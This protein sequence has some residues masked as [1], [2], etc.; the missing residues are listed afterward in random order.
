M[1]IIIGILALVVLFISVSFFRRKK[2]Y[3]DVDRLETWKVSIMNKPVSEELSKVKDLNMTGQTEELFENWRYQWDDILTTELIH[4][5]EYLFDAEEFVDKYRFG[6][7][8]EVLKIADNKLQDIEKKIQ[9]I[10]DELEELIGSQAKSVEENEKLEIKY[11]SLKKKLLNQMHQYGSIT[12][13][14]EKELDQIQKLFEEFNEAITNG[15]YLVARELVARVEKELEVVEAKI[16]HIP[17]LLIDCQSVLPSQ[18]A[19]VETGYKEMMEEGYILDH[20]NLEKN[21]RELQ[22]KLKHISTQLL[23]TKVLEAKEG[24]DLLKKEMDELYDEIEKEVL[25]KHFVVKELPSVNAILT[26]LSTASEKTKHE[27]IVVQESYQLLEED[28]KTQRKIEESM[29]VLNERYEKLSGHLENQTVAFS[30][31]KEELEDICEQINSLQEIHQQYMDSLITL[32]KDEMAAREQVS[33]L[34]KMLFEVKRSIEKSNIPGLPK[35]VYQELA[36][37]N[38]HLKAVTEKLEE[39]PLNISNVNAILGEAVE[40]VEKCHQEALDI[41]DHAYLAESIIQYGNRYRSKHPSVHESLIEAE[42]LFRN[43]EYKSALEEAAATLEKVEPGVLNKI[44]KILE[45]ED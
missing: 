28:I 38:D 6:K 35:S 43:Y 33:A 42:Q 10:Y 3:E 14:L 2:I 17:S 20:V 11:T 4:I 5:E 34:R 26:A 45:K 12:P 44:E 29:L 36:L 27:T 22:D 7:A 23:E 32:R 16:E 25:A 24:I 41:L 30:I 1:E 31:L 37:S 18:L 21:V 9:A 40:S 39:K 19:E 8:K 13:L 15:N